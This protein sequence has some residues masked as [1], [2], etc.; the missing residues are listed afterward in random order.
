MNFNREIT[1]EPVFY[2]SITFEIKL[3]RMNGRDR[4]G[5]GILLRCGSKLTDNK[6]ATK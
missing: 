5:E 3:K 6:C 1:I 4:E 2:E